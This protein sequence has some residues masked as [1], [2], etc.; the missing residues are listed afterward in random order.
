MP[1]CRQA[2][3][4]VEVRDGRGKKVTWVLR[5]AFLNIPLGAGQNSP[6]LQHKLILWCFCFKGFARARDEPK[7]ALDRI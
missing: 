5:K 3:A 7:T 1:P 2:R 4:L 6:R